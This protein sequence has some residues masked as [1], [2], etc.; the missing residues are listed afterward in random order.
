MAQ[1]DIPKKQYGQTRTHRIREQACGC[2]K[3]EWD[4][5]RKKDWEFRLKD[6]NYYIDIDN[7]DPISRTQKLWFNFL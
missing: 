5:G 2:L 6:V 3:G 4:G 1:M 7:K